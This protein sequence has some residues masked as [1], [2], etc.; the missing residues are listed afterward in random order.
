[1]AVLTIAIVR[2]S[3]PRARRVIA[4]YPVTE[5]VADPLAFVIQREKERAGALVQG[6]RESDVAYLARATRARRTDGRDDARPR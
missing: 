6:A 2:R 4:S 1:M 3:G 5:R